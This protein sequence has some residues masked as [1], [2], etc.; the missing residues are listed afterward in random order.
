MNKYI[1]VLPTILIGGIVILATII[2]FFLSGTIAN[3]S[4]LDWVGFAFV[5]LSEIILYITTVGFLSREMTSSK[6]INL[7]GVLSTLSI[8]MII[9]ICLY[10]F[11]NIFKEHTNMFISI[12]I[13]LAAFTA[14]ISILLFTF[15]QGIQGSDENL[16]SSRQVMDE[17]ESKIYILMSQKEY[18]EFHAPMKEIYEMIKY[19]DKC[20]ETSIDYSIIN[21]IGNLDLLLKYNAIEEKQNILNSIDNI[22]SKIQIRNMELL[23]SKKGGF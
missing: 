23:N 1:R 6:V 19:G 12:Q 14:I 3:K 10:F 7:T 5:I 11:R 18:K 13:A 20:G 9:T 22:K 2:I 8:Y 15:A 16:Q 17:C 21:E 4:Y